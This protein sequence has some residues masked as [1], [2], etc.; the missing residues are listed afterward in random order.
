MGNRVTFI[1]IVLL[2]MG[3]AAGDAFAK[4]PGKGRAISPKKKT[5]NV[6]SQ[7]VHKAHAEG[8]KG[9]DVAAAGH[10]AIGEMKEGKEEEKTAGQ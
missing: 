9:K 10:K 3:L 8:L 7:A 6:V 2:A 1:F 5:G 4:G